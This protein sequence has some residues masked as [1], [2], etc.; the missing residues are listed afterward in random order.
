MATIL[1]SMAFGNEVLLNAHD[2]SKEDIWTDYL[3]KRL[4]YAGFETDFIPNFFV[5]FFT[6]SFVC[7]FFSKPTSGELG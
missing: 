3:G 6:E 1:L 5:S 7:I 4:T 2:N